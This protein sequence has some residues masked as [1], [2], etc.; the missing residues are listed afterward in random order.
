MKNNFSYGRAP[1]PEPR[2]KLRVGKW[3]LFKPLTAMQKEQ[4]CEQYKGDRAFKARVIKEYQRFYL[5]ETE[6]YMMTMLKSALGIEWE[7]VER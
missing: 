3:Y 5:L 7:A 2:P 6:N 1:W 4:K